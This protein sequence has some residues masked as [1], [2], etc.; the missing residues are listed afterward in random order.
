MDTNFATSSAARISR[1]EFTPPTTI[2]VPS[3][4]PSGISGTI[5]AVRIGQRPRWLHFRFVCGIAARWALRIATSMV[6]IR[7]W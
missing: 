2:N 6:G 3:T 4:W 5:T 1:F 7:C